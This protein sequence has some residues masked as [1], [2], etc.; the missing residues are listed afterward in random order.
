MKTELIIFGITGF[1]I[2]N[3]YYDGKY[4]E[5]IK[6]YKKYFQMGTIGFVGLSLYL[7]MKK[8]PSH[9]RDMVK[10]ANNFIKY[11]PIDRTTASMITPIVDFT[12][13]NGS[14]YG[15]NIPMQNNNQT[16]SRIMTSG[17]RSN[18]KKQNASNTI[19]RSVSE[20]KKK[21]V[22]ARQSWKCDHCKNMLDATYEI[23]HVVELQHGGTNHVDNLVALCRNCH[24]NKTLQSHL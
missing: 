4:I 21:Y 7:F 15:E 20:P 12:L 2:Y 3:T 13:S 22:A 5:K 8:K 11:M 1:L 14:N 17:G 16:N 10:Y 9:S 19:K 18:S 6:S 24:G 23:D